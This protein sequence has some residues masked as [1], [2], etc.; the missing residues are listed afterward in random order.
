MDCLQVDH[1]RR[2]LGIRHPSVTNDLLAVQTQRP[3]VAVAVQTHHRLVQVQTEPLELTDTQIDTAQQL[4][5][6]AASIFT[7]QSLCLLLPG[8]QIQ[9]GQT[10]THLHA[11]PTGQL[12]TATTKYQLA[13]P[14]RQFVHGRGIEHVSHIRVAEAE[15]SLRPLQGHAELAVA[16]FVGGLAERRWHVDREPFETGIDL[17]LVVTTPQVEL[18]LIRQ[19]SG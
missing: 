10:S 2:A 9:F 18:Q 14:L 12:S 1:Q 11:L 5:G 8:L 13:T 3:V 6:T 19:L 15:A 4:S 7:R 16:G 17:E